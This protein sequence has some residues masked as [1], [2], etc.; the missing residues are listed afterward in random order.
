MPMTDIWGDDEWDADDSGYGDTKFW[1]KREPKKPK[2]SESSSYHSYAN[3]VKHMTPLE[4]EERVRD[5]E[6][7]IRRLDYE[8]DRN[9]YLLGV[10]KNAFDDVVEGFQHKAHEANTAKKQVEELKQK[11][12]DLQTRLDNLVKVGVFPWS[13][14]AP[15]IANPLDDRFISIEIVSHEELIEQ[16]AKQRK[17]GEVETQ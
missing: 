4:I 13:V 10:N 11:N 14:N 1:Q 12:K 2:S 9:E 6:E 8:N 7:E 15:K 17:K 16:K 5:L 3:Y